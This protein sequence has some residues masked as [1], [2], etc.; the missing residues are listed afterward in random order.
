MSHRAINFLPILCAALLLCLLAGP[1]L[2]A[3]SPEPAALGFHLGHGDA[4]H[5][6]AARAAG[7]R[8]AVVVF[9]WANLEPEPGYFYWQEPD[10]A[11]RAAQ[12]YGLD[13]LARLDQPPAWALTGNPA[14]PI[15]GA[16]YAN[17]ARRV[18]ERYG[19]RLAGLILWNEPNLSLE[20]A[21]YPPDAAAYAEL[22]KAAY[23]A[24]KAA[25]P[26]L[27]VGL[28]GLAPTE[29][30]G[31]WAVN[32]LDYLQ[33]LYAAG[34]GPYFDVLTAHPY[35]FG[36]P[37]DDAP[38]KYRPN[39]RRLEL[40]REVMAA[41][42]DAPKPV[43]VTE[44]GWLAWTKNPHSQWQVV[45]PATQA[46]YLLAAIDLARRDYPWLTRLGLWQLNTAGDEYGFGIWHGAANSSPAYA[47]LAAKFGPTEAAPPP[48]PEALLTILAPDVTIRRGDRDTL[49][50]HWVHL[51]QRGQDFSPEWQ[52]E[53]FLSEGQ[54]AR[55]F[56]LVLETMQVTQPT[57]RIL[58]NG[59][60]VATL[61]QR[62]RPDITSTWVTQRFPLPPAVLRPG[63]N[64]IRLMIG[65]RNP[66]R[67]YVT[68]HWE[69]MQFRHLRLIPAAPPPT[70]LVSEWQPQPSPGGW[71][72]IAR[73][74]GD[75][76]L[77]GHRAGQVWQIEAGPPLRL[78]PRRDNRPDLVFHDVLSTTTA[79]PLA[80][81]DRG[82][83]RRT[84][85]G[86]QAIDAGPTGHAYAVQQ[87]AG[88]F[89]AG[90]EGAGL[91]QA[92]TPTGPWRPSTL[93]ATTV[94]ELPVGPDGTLYALT[95][96]EIYA[97][98]GEQWALLPLPGLSDEALRDNGE[99]P[100]DKLRPALFFATDG[101]LVV[102]RQDRL[103]LKTADGWQLLGPEEVQG[104]A[105]SVLDCCGAGAI[106]G[107]SK[108]GLWQRGDD[109]GWRRLDDGVFSVTDATALGRVGQ[110]LLA[111]GE[112]GLFAAGDGGTAWQAVGG[113]PPPV[114]DLLV[115]P[116][117]PAR[118][119]AG[120]PAGVYLSRDAGQSWQTVS[121][122]WT[123]WDLAFGPQGRLFVARS[124]GLGWA[125]D[126]A[127]ASI[128]W[129]QAAGMNQ[130]FFLR[131]NPHPTDPQVVWGGTWGNNIGASTDG[132]QNS[133]PIHH[134]LETLS[135]LDI[136]WHP[137]PGQV[138]LATIEGLYRTD[139]GGQSWFKLPGP[140]QQQT[141]NSLVQSA[142]GTIWAGAADGL[143]RSDDYGSSWVRVE[144]IPEVS[145]VRL[146]QLEAGQIWAGTEG[147]GLWLS[148]DEG[149]TWQW[150]G[151]AGRT[152]Y[153]VFRHP[154]QSKR[155]VAATDTGIFAGEVDF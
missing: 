19:N 151:L 34:A 137:A 59:T 111:A 140:L 101:R 2:H 9:S 87:A 23:P 77:L 25:A 60:E 44:M 1:S 14:A 154:A 13:L 130:V 5:F 93:T 69:N 126:L 117:V 150:A 134:G 100:G 153:Q 123:V 144:T 71:A 120:T 102:R 33:A 73:L 32:D 72:E 141:V 118:G 47:A 108:A 20:W 84:E 67:Q 143:W 4:T 8:F 146:G 46:D 107:T 82:L 28:A 17:F 80:A 45:S 54:A 97:R 145:V 70:P 39:F 131:A 96:A 55:P 74:T 11:L 57:N 30:E 50:P 56:D 95:P 138:T 36:R 133:D 6:E 27:P 64:R 22:L 122:P 65:P 31:D 86:W 63:V 15:D 51:L 3:Q 114:R 92:P 139:D 104:Q 83:F 66:G 10:A 81:A 98:R 91:W 61:R 135:G 18:A 53:F 155:L 41:H 16:A 37:P 152:V 115:A 127:A 38:E 116:A 124:N 43:W 148:R 49:Y 7:G 121:P 136:L 42:D 149:Q 12:F 113:L 75:G 68:A 112:I 35:G 106:I 142:G 110:T 129:R 105:W 147:A 88:Q 40:Y 79:V 99:W 94:V 103:W 125:D 76:W 26:N 29:G 128:A 90:F 58:I 89:W 132:G 78:L 21:N 24:V 109:G 119:G 52:G 85:S 62:A 48:P